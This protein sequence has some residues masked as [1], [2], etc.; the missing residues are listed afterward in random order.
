[1]ARIDDLIAE[2]RD[3]RVRRA[4]VA[5]VKKLRELEKF[6]LVFKNHLLE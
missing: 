5:E 1:M 3:E 2:I 4:V 6:W